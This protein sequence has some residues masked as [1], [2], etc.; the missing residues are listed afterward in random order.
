MAFN[1]DKRRHPRLVHRAKV[2]V[3]FADGEDSQLLMHDLSESGM[4]ISCKNEVLPE[5]GTTVEVQTLEFEDAPIIKA[6]VT[7][8]DAGNGFA[9]Q[10]IS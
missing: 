5:I 10:F 3:N 7:R 9:V 4:F 1:D 2:R 8:V 6:K